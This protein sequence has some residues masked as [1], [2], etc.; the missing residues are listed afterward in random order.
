[1]WLLWLNLPQIPQIFA[2]L[3]GELCVYKNT[4]ITDNTDLH[5]LYIILILNVMLNLF[6]HIIYVTLQSQGISTFSMWLLWLKSP[7]DHA[8][9]RRIVWTTMCL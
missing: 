9:F 5:E 1:M 4:N 2:E 7:A 6:Q 8:D 3:Y